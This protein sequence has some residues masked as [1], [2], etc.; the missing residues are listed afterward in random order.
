MHFFPQ[1]PA[2]G[3]TENFGRSDGWKIFRRPDGEISEGRTKFLLTV[4]RKIFGPFNGSRWTIERSSDGRRTETM[5][6]CHSL[7][8]L[9]QRISV[10]AMAVACRRSC[11]WSRI[12]SLVFGMQTLLR[13]LLS[14]VSLCRRTSPNAALTLMSWSGSGPG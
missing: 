5:A 14:K 2:I 10:P 12:M 4:G 1:S 8:F 3:Q 9:N 7:R 13:Q 6:F 11:I